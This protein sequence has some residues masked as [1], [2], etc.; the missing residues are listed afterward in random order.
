MKTVTILKRLKACQG[1]IEWAEGYP[2]LQAAWDACPRGDWML[3]FLSRQKMPLRGAKHKAFIRVIMGLESRNSCKCS[4]CTRDRKASHKALK[5][6]LAGKKQ[7][8]DIHA[9]GSEAWAAADEP[10]RSYIFAEYPA[11][12]VRKAYPKVPV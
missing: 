1:A 12:A 8:K 2:D 10:L 5:A 3:W 7:W 9:H 4:A 6:W 11:D